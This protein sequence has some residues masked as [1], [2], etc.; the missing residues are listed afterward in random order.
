MSS[1]ST[2]R[3]RPC[4][5]IIRD[6]WGHNPNSD[7]DKFNA[8]KIANT[9]TDD[10]LMNDYPNTLMH[11]SGE[12]VGLPNGTMGNSEVGHQNIGAGRVVYQ[13]SVRITLKI[14]DESFYENEVLLEAMN[15]VKQNSSKL[16]IMGLCSDIGVHSLLGHL[17]GVLEMAKR[18]GVEE[19]Y[20]HALTDGRDSSPTSGLGFLKDI[21]AKMN[22]IGVGKIAS[23]SGRFYAMDRDNR[24]ERVSKAYN[25]LTKGEGG[26]SGSFEQAMQD[27]YAREETDEFIKPLNITGEDGKPLSLIEDG[28]SVVF[29]NFRGDRPREITRAFVDDDFAGF[30]RDKKLDLQFVCMTQY[31]KTINAPVAFPKPPKMK[32]ILGEY[33]SSLGLKQFRCAETE[34]YA[35]VT[36]FF[37]DYREEPFEKED[38]QIIPSPKVETYDL[39]PEMSANKVCDAV[40]E[41]LEKNE[42]DAI[43]VNFANPDMVGH[44]G[45]LD[46]A[47][48]ACET[49]DECV[50]KIL[51]KV[52]EMN[53]TAIVFADHGNSEKMADGN[54]DNP[55]T[56]HTTGDVPFIVFDEELKNTALASGGCLADAAPTMLELMGI[57][58]PKEMTGRSLIQKNGG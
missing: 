21:Q 10:M 33:L 12:M 16:H 4:V 22:E 57:E 42:F 29:F 11:T 13:D 28:D 19:V 9:P 5:M 25:C 35:H 36:F 58:K 43:I 53:G 41:R 40:M 51:S 45:V 38:R 14:R 46:A 17:Y 1:K 49:V 8:I 48:T 18:N 39:Q 15:R 7:D 52:K 24:W 3:K 20:L 47:V 55:F 50:G 23:I 27:C 34:K 32:N 56:S 30:Q 54:P 31:D 26:K 37:N 2:I 44:T 6:G